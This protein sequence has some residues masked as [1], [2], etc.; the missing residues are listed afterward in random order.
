VEEEILVAVVKGDGNLALGRAGGFGGT[1]GT[2]PEGI[3]QSKLAGE[4][5]GM[6]VVRSNLC[7]GTRYRDLVV[8]QDGSA[9]FTY[10][11]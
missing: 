2:V 7:T 9:Q 11:L 8:H 5:G 3:Q 6:Y 10:S 1:N 4:R